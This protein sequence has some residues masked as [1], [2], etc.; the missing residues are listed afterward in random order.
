MGKELGRWQLRP[1]S[2]AK[3]FP[4]Y[5]PKP[6]R[7]DYEEACLIRDLSPK[8]AATLARRCLQGIIRDFW[9]ISKAR[10]VDEINDLKGVI[11][12]AT[13]EAIDAVRS[14]GNIGAHMERDINLVIEV[15]PEEAQLL[16]GLIE[17]LL[18][19]WY[20]ARHERQAHLQ[21]IVALA[22]SKK[23]AAT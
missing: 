15:E 6:I 14:I 13:W 4:N 16:I 1:N 18:K 2:S 12:Q 20:I 5:I 22:K 17:V 9:G 19:D 8:A 21:Q 7:E 10:L 23:P 11:D 3:V